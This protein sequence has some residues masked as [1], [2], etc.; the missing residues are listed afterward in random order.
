MLYTR[1]LVSNTHSILV[2]EREFGYI[3]L[4]VNTEDGYFTQHTVYPHFAEFGGFSFARI[5]SV[6]SDLWDFELNGASIV[7]L[8][9]ENYIRHFGMHF[10]KF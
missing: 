2:I 3:H 1:K 5:S 6:L 10:M 7:L 8:D 4:Y 9:Y